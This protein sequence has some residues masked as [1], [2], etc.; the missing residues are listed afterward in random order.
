MVGRAVTHSLVSAVYYT[1]Q[2]GA[3]ME[4]P[5]CLFQM[6]PYRSEQTP[7]RNSEEPSHPQCIRR[8]GT[9][10]HTDGSSTY[11]G[12]TSGD[13]L[14][15]QCASLLHGTAWYCKVSDLPTVPARDPR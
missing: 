13:V 1:I 6:K 2:G 7:A 5:T 12:S 4:H 15:P 10:T 14:P 11:K 3:K 8:Y 9:H